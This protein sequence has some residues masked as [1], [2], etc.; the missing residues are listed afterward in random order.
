[1]V[2]GIIVGAVLVNGVMVVMMVAVVMVVITV[3]VVDVVLYLTG[4]LMDVAVKEGN[5]GG[6]A[7]CCG[8]WL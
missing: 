1:M 7:G 5:G 4:M 6:Y 3:V 8:Q 2:A